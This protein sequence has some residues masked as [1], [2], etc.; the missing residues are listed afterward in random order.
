M[1]AEGISVRGLE[2]LVSVQDV[3]P[4]VRTKRDN[5]AHPDLTEI[6]TRLGERL[7]TRCRIEMGKKKGRLTVEFAS[8]DDLR[9]ILDLMAAPAA[10]P[11]PSD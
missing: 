7:D 8:V 3:P 4:R 10:P 6:A 11:S 1:V 5:T 2:E 9:R